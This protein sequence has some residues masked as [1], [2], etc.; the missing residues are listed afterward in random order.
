MS[1]QIIAA[2][3]RED[4]E[5]RQGVLY[6]EGGK[7]SRSCA[8]GGGWRRTSYSCRRPLASATATRGPHATAAATPTAAATFAA[9]PIRRSPS[10]LIQRHRVEDRLQREVLGPG[11]S[12]ILSDRPGQPQSIST[13]FEC[14]FAVGKRMPGDKTQPE[15]RSYAPLLPGRAPTGEKE[16]RGMPM[17]PATGQ[18]CRPAE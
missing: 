8:P 14:T 17:L 4:R 11:Q 1:P 16:Y 2:W 6:D 7:A 13:R 15:P 9:I 3:W 18:H 12:D 5:I 10:A